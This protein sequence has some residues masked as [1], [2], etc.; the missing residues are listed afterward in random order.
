ML[1]YRRRHQEASAAAEEAVQR[2]PNYAD[3]YAAL[4]QVLNYRG[5]TLYALDRMEIAKRLDPKYPPYYDFQVGQAYYVWGF[6][7]AETGR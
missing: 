7:T 5:Q 2:N 1:L 3:G 6:L 4:A